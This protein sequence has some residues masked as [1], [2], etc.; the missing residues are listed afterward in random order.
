VITQIVSIF[1][2]FQRVIGSRIN[3]KVHCYFEFCKTYLILMNWTSRY[4]VQD[5]SG[6]GWDNSVLTTIVWYLLIVNIFVLN[7]LSSSLIYDPKVD[8][9]RRVFG[10]L[11][12]GRTP[13]INWHIVFAINVHRYIQGRSLL[14]YSIEA[15]AILSNLEYI[16]DQFCFKI[17][18]KICHSYTQLYIH[19]GHLTCTT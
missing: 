6:L 10:H 17:V 8:G 18:I 2:S 7:L 4:S 15:G 1:V 11:E 5:S 3:T 16:W 12:P 19:N 14:C 9:S 13:E